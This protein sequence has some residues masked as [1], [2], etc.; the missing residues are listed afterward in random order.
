M[1]GAGRNFRRCPRGIAT[2]EFVLVAPILLLLLLGIAELG[3]A[4]YQYNTLSKAVRGATRY[5]SAN[6]L[7]NPTAAAAAAKSLVMQN[8]QDLPGMAEGDI[9]PEIEVDPATG[10][11]ARLTANYTFHFIPGNPLSGI[12]RLL[13]GTALS[14]SFL[15]TATMTMRAI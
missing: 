9:T 6:V 3:R 4:L 13:G 8:T 14:D 1:N 12:I 15:M 5:Y 10:N 11:W 7:A 2:L